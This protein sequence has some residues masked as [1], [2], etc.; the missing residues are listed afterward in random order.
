[1]KHK[2]TARR[3]AHTFSPIHTSWE[4]AERQSREQAGRSNIL[5]PWKRLK[6]K[7]VAVILQVKCEYKPSA[8]K[9]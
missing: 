9:N 7:Q 4:T 5:S 6:A 1:M 8:C 3:K 2:K